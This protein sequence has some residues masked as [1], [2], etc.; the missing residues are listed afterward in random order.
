MTYKDPPIVDQLKP[1]PPLRE[2]VPASPPPKQ[3]PLKRPP[4]Q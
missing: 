3:L 1:H 4:K 2:G